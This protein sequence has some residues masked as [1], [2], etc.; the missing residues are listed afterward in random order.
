MTHTQPRQKTCN[1]HLIDLGKEAQLFSFH[2][3]IYL[4]MEPRVVKLPCG[5]HRISYL[6]LRKTTD[7]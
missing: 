3:N 4:L 2:S 6:I 7:N 1:Y 5:I